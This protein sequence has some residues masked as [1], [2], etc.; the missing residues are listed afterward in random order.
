MDAVA[1]FATLVWPPTGIA[2]FALWRGGRGLW[3]AVFAAAFVVNALHGAP[4]LVAGGIAVGNTLEALAGAALLRRVGFGPSL[5]RVRDVLALAVLGAVVSTTISA[6]IGVLSLRAGGVIATDAMRSAWTA[7]WVGDALGDLV[8]APL[9]F[10]WSTRI[11]AQQPRS[12][13]RMLEA[14]TLGVVVPGV[15]WLLFGS[16]SKLGGASSPYLLF[17]VLIV[18]ALR[19]GPRGATAASFSASAI[20]VLGAV[21]GRGPFQQDSLG[22]TLFELQAFMAVSDMTTILL[23]AAVAERDRAMRAAETAVRARDEFLSVASHEIR[24]PLT[25]LVLDVASLRRAEERR[26]SPDERVSART[27][28]IERHVDRLTLLV[29]RL[30]DVSRITA[31]RL[32]PD[33]EDVDADAVVREVVERFAGQ[34]SAAAC[35]VE[36]RTAGPCIGRWDRLRL[37]QVLTNL[38]SNACKYGAG[39][40]IEVRLTCTADA[41]VIAV[42]DH[43][44]GIQPSDQARVF[45]RFERA[46]SGRH[47]AGL[48]VGLWVVRQIVQELGGNVVLD[49]VAG[50]GSTFTVTLP[51]RRPD[52]QLG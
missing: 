25:G 41:C 4:V 1:G 32:E 3:P 28:A 23:A 21:L 45:E 7:W 26:G 35:T 29:E 17:P 22:A 52:Q 30:I 34:A 42:Q 16:T 46:V 9:L 24:T 39:K 38:L 44:I 18:A 14:A 40:P 10:V 15:A 49:S 43:G 20:A 48:G 2:L 47:F 37:D 27:A 12:P 50:E 13:R 36:L 11:T 6:S 19:F 5:S 8:V 51:R 33:L 31:G